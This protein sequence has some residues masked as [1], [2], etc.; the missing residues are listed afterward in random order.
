MT[1]T[2][3]AQEMRRM[4]LAEVLGLSGIVTIITVIPI[5]CFNYYSYFGSDELRKRQKQW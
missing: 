5:T 2:D 1:V 4:C 3:L